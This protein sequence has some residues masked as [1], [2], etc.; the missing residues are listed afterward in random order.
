MPLTSSTQPI[1][2]SRCP[3]K[4]SSPVVSVS[5]TITRIF[6]SRSR[7]AARES[8]PP[9]RHCSDGG[10]DRTHLGAGG[11]ES[12]RGVHDKIGAGALLGVGHLPRQNGLELLH[13]HAGP[14]EH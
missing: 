12:M 1:S 11:V 2:T 13:G 8:P 3:W 14:L 9:L 4:G 5:S 7:R 6:R 10:E